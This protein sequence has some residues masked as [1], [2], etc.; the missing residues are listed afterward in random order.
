MF[1]SG[2]NGY[3]RKKMDTET[4]FQILGEVV[5]ILHCVNAYEKGMKQTIFHPAIGK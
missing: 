3:C 1:F 2:W 4:R 5:C